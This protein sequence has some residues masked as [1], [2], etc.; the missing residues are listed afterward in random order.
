MKVRV[1][2]DGSEYI[3]QKKSWYWPFWRK[4]DSEVNSTTPVYAFSQQDHAL[5]FVATKLLKPKPPPKPKWV[6]A[7]CHREV[8]E[9]IDKCVH[10]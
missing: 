2:S 6:V 3:V 4:V 1:I 10:S 9:K 8:V 5:K 7:L